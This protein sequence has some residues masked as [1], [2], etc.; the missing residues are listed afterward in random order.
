MSAEPG[1]VPTRQFLSFLM[2]ADA[3]AVELSHVHEIVRFESATRVPRVPACIRGV[4]NLRG[5]V[6]PVI[7]LAVGL[8]MTEAPVTP[9]SCL[10]VVEATLGRERSVVGLIADAVSQVLDLRPEDIEP[11]PSFGTRVPATFLLGMVRSESGFV[12]LLD[13][14]RLLGV[15]GPLHGMEQERVVPETPPPAGKATS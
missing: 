7:D 3:C 15:D 6:V 4:V 11:A 9:R 12:Q 14:D 13:L 10:L 5:N 1:A 8:A 2:G